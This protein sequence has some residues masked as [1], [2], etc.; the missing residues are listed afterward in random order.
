MAG[1]AALAGGAFAGLG[2]LAI[3][4]K[5]S[6]D[7]WEEMADNIGKLGTPVVDY[8]KH[9]LTPKLLEM[10]NKTKNRFLYEKINSVT[11]NSMNSIFTFGWW[12]N[13][14]MLKFHAGLLSTSW[15]IMSSPSETQKL[16][17]Q[18]PLAPKF[19]IEK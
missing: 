16:I 3:K 13:S 6:S 18:T 10:V 1:L 8:S 19:R 7:K 4:S 2:T 14:N 12:K 11:I 9:E 17:G 5:E 15:I